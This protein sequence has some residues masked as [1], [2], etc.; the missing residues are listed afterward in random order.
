MLYA[1]RNGLRGEI[2]FNK[3]LEDIATILFVGNAIDTP[4]ATI[5]LEEALMGLFGRF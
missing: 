4:D 1:L 2:A 5:L 3:N